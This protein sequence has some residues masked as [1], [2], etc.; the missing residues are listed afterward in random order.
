MERMAAKVS[1]LRPRKEFLS[2]ASITVPLAIFTTLAI[3]GCSSFRADPKK[4]LGSFS[5]FAADEESTVGTFGGEQTPT[6]TPS[7]SPAPTPVMETLKDVFKG[8]P[9]GAASLAAICQNAGAD[10]FTTALCGP[11][12]P[13][14]RSLRDLHS[15]L[16]LNNAANSACTTNSVSLVKNETSVLNPRCIKFSANGQANDATA[17]GYLR[18]DLTFAE[19]VARDPVT[20]ILRFFLVDFDLPCEQQPG[21]CATGDFYLESAESN[22]AAVSI[23]EDSQ[24]ENTVMDCKMCHQ[25]GGPNARK[26]LRMAETDDPWRHWIRDN[27]QCG[28]TLFADFNAAHGGEQFYAGL[29]LNEVSNSD[30]QRLENFVEDN[31]FQGAQNGNNFFNS[32]QIENQTD[33]TAGQPQSNANTSTSATW[34]A[35]YVQ[36]TSAVNL[37]NF[38]G[39]MMPYR[40]CKQSDPLMLPM[41]T[42]MFRQV[43]AGTMPAS[44]LPPLQNVNL[45]SVPA[46]RERSLLPRAGLD[47]A[48]I[49]ANACVSCHNSNLNPNISRS[50]FN[51]QDLSRMPAAEFDVAINRI[52]RAKDDLRRMPPKTFMNLTP[53]EI[54]VLS[55][56]LR[57]Q[58]A[59]RMAP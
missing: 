57:Q 52:S 22:W 42:N 48:G 15:A 12:P 9:K 1:R 35:T 8:L 54:T 33:N 2:S 26:L 39:V 14:I 17:V 34:M 41:F 11:N 45:S 56:Y 46:L 4:A 28:T 7:P 44:L 37:I 23:Y 10:R 49:L 40:D 38:G 43:R 19:V 25:P 24:I 16:G 29:T 32:N 30:P 18:A 55:D 31:G 21:G 58:K 3:T 53:E 20:G 6:P 50:R 13:A 36:R 51:A 59:L 5:S 47:G 27:R